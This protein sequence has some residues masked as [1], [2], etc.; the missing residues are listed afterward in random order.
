MI[1]RD[2]I[3][4]GSRIY[5]ASKNKVVAAS[6]YGKLKTAFQMIAII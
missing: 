4:D 6:V 3:V 5:A 2:V 1:I